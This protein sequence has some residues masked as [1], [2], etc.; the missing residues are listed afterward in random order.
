MRKAEMGEVLAMLLG[1]AIAIVLADKDESVPEEERAKITVD[2]LEGL[3]VIGDKYYD[4]H[5]DAMIVSAKLHLEIMKA[6]VDDEPST[7]S[8][9]PKFSKL[10]T[11]EIDK[12]LGMGD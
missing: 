3:M 6:L 2:C 4:D 7:I 12:L 5:R 9:Q 10:A 11:K 8:K 1:Q